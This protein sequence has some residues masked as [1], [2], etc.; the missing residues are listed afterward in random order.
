MAASNQFTMLSHKQ[1]ENTPVYLALY[2]SLYG[3]LCL[4]AS[5]TGY[6]M[7]VPFHY[8]QF[9]DT[10]P[11]QTS[12]AQSL[13]YLHAQPPLPN[14]WLGLAL[15]LA[16]AGGPSVASSLLGLQLAMGAVVVVG[17]YLLALRLLPGRWLP[18]LFIL[19]WLLNPVFYSN[20]FIYF[21]PIH[22]LFWLVVVLGGSWHYLQR[23]T[24]VGWMLAAM[25]LVGLVYSRSLFHPFWA[26]AF[27][28]GLFW[29][30]SRRHTTKRA[31][32]N[33]L[34]LGITAVSLLLWP[35]KNQYLFGFFGYSSWQGYNMAQGLPVDRTGIT[36]VFTTEPAQAVPAA[37]QS[38]PVLAQPQKSDGSAN[39]NYYPIILYAQSLQVEVAAQTKTRPT[40][41]W[42][43]IRQNYRYGYGLHAGRNTYEG[44]FDLRSTST[45]FHY[46]WIKGPVLYRTGPLHFRRRGWDS[47]PR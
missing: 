47:N 27:M 23:G 32:G 28:A 17:L 19:F 31:A 11:L 7:I 26:I 30:A 9:L 44:G 22:E 5:A 45:P 38:V 42:E 2:L 8:F 6:Q 34:L 41:W 18:N 1:Q 39:W 35:L 13:W 21:Y 40:I 33:W 46:W 37:W 3:G 25:G 20:L 16:G 10:A 24:M 15:K 29:L 36:A 4:L 12:L 14:L 43:K